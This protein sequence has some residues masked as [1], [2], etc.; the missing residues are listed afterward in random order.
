MTQR[1]RDR[2]VVPKARK[3]LIRQWQAAQE[4]GISTRQVK[5]LQPA[6][7]RVEVRDTVNRTYLL[8]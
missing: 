8:V 1:D 5:R 4:L 6:P 2:L 7:F 3:K